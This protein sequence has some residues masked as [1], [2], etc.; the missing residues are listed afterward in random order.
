M[1]TIGIYIYE[2]AEV[3]DFAGP[4]EV[5]STAKRLANL[6]W[7]VILIAETLEPVVAR[8]GFK[9]IPDYAI[10]NHPILDLLMVVGGIH[11]NETKKNNVIKWIAQTAPT[12]QWLASV[13]TGAFLLAQAQLLDHLS[14]TTHWEDINDL[15]NDYPSLTVISN[16]RWV[17][18]GNIFTSAGISAGIDMSLQLVSELTTTELAIKTAKQMDYHWQL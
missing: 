15:A 9:V 11:T 8:G 10:D 12:T 4:F 7:E 18:C 1:K 5:F 14:V 2:N 17:K 3:L 13:C 16:Q 6:H